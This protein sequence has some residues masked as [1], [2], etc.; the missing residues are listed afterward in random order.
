MYAIFPFPLKNLLLQKKG[1]Y[2]L[3]DK[4]QL[5]EIYYVFKNSRLIAHSLSL[6]LRR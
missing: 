5:K 4:Y 1:V 3:Q 6:R 2:R